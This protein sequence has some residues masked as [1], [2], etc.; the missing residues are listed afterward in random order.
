MQRQTVLVTGGAAGIGEGIAQVLATRGWQVLVNDVDAEGAQRVAQAVGGIALPG[1]VRN[2][3]QGLVAQAVAA[4]GALH[5]L[6]NNAGIIRRSPLADT[7]EAELDVVYGINLKAMVR[8]SQVALPHLQ[9]SAGAIVNIS[10]IAAESPQPAAGFYSMSKA[11]VSA[12]TRQAAL[13]WGPR[14]VR[15]NAVAPGLIR[16][17]MAEAVYSVPELHEKRRMMMPLRR[18]GVPAEIGKVVAFLLSDDASYVSGQV[19]AVDGGF[20]QTLIDHL[21]HPPT[22]AF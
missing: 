19:I 9:A 4:G 18:I 10:S 13:E 14:G 8:L 2:D 17:A 12:F 5:A 22:P 7:T 15:V 1:D 6:V 20:T 16:T 3:P 21:P 11:G